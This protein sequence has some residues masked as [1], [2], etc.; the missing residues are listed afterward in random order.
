V[1]PRNV[2]SPA[3]TNLIAVLVAKR[4]MPEGIELPVDDPKDDGYSRKLGKPLRDA[5]ILTLRKILILRT[6]THCISEVPAAVLSLTLRR[7]VVLEPGK[8]DNV[9]D[10]EFKLLQLRRASW[11]SSLL[12]EMCQKQRRCIQTRSEKMLIRRAACS[13]LP[14]ARNKWTKRECGGVPVAS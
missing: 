3:E 4:D 1:S 9:T 10:L 14:Q 2:A 7:E 12:S 5:A 11:P 8:F 13:D 6:R